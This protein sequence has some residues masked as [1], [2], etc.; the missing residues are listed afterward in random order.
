MDQVQSATSEH[1]KRLPH[2]RLDQSYHSVIPYT[3]TF[4]MQGIRINKC[5]RMSNDT[6]QSRF[7]SLY[8]CPPDS[9]RFRLYVFFL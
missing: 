6:E 9:M 3:L 8:Y 7:H 5:V 1:K 2:Q 4:R